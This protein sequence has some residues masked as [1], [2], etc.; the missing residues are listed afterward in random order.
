MKIRQLHIDGFGLF[1]D[2]SF[3]P[4]TQPVTVFLGPNE[5][6]KS[7]LLEFVRRVL[8]G[9]PRRSGRVNRYPALAGGAYGGQLSIEDSSGRSYEVRRTSG[10]TYRGKVSITSSSGEFLS[11]AILA[12]LLGNHTKDVFEQVFAFTLGELHSDDLFENKDVNSQIYSAGLGVT[13]L[14]R[15]MKHIDTRQR[16]IFLKSGSKQKISIASKEIDEINE[17]LSIVEGNAKRF[18]DLSDSLNEVETELECLAAQRQQIRSQQNHQNMLKRAWD[19]WNDLESAKRELASLP[20]VE[21]FPVGGVARLEIM[22][23]RLKDAE[24]E[25]ESARTRVTDAKRE[26]KASV[27]HE[28]ILNYSSEIQ[29]LQNGLISFDDADEDLP[30]V[31]TELNGHKKDLADALKDLGPEWDKDKLQEFDLSITVR[32]DIAGHRDQ[33]SNAATEHRNSVIALDRDKNSL[34]EAVDAERRARQAFESSIDPSLNIEQIRQR[35]RL[36][37]EAR[38]Q[39]TEI[40]RIRLDVQNL[41][42]Q[43]DDL[44]TTAPITGGADLGKIVGAAS[45]VVGVGIILG[46]AVLGGTALLMSI[47]AGISLSGAAIFLLMSGK[48]DRATTP[49]SPPSASIQ[50]SIRQAH[51]KIQDL[52]SKLTE[53]AIQLEIDHIDEASLLTIEEFI[54]EEEHRLNEW[55]RLS[56]AY[57]ASMNLRKLRL[58]RVDESSKAVEYRRQTRDKEQRKWREWLEVRGLLDTFTPDTA[59]VLQGQI[60]LA[61]TRLA[62]VESWQHR[63][64]Q[65]EGSIDKY[66]SSVEALATTFGVAFDRSDGRRVAVAAA[67]LI[68]LFDEVRKNISRRT[69]AESELQIAES[70]LTRRKD[71]RSQSR[72]ELRGLLESGGSADAEEFRTRSELFKKRKMLEQKVK[73]ALD[74]LQ[75]ISGPGERLDKL[76]S[77]LAMSEILSIEE[78]LEELDE[79]QMLVESKR[80]EL[81]SERGSIN[82]ILKGLMDEKESS[83]LRIERNVRL[84][85]LK[86]HARDWSRFALAQKL[87]EETRRRFERERQPDVIRHAESFLRR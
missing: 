52:H 3:G 42:G 36:V 77:D 59:D 24:H 73:T 82:T 62:D 51:S 33:L 85:Q 13:S 46:G 14:P 7:T 23:E 30:R 11:E 83:Q 20:V 35:R 58:A 2:V 21:N 80:N 6:G 43:L 44:D 66:I 54:D 29:Y 74:R 41:E 12:E 27:E 60:Q 53:K 40:N 18:S 16:D 28:D 79:K 76:K 1:S 78:S 86:G 49:E 25:Y 69:S 5:A 56:E 19:D 34:G 31:R 9:F 75:H 67:R 57:K 65:M 8:Y 72:K 22:E 64:E 10:N 61:R 4:F 63:I 84:E 87:L 17:K 71:E 55:S 47:I 50:S 37:R 68:E 15:A 70:Q 48:P 38:F 26:A 45:L 32:Q 39:L 81:S